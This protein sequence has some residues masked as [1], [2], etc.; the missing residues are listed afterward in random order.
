MPDQELSCPRCKGAM[1]HGFIADSGLQI[2]TWYATVGRGRARAL[3]LF[4]P[5]AEGP[6]RARRANVQVHAMRIPRVV[7]HNGNGVTG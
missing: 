2:R 4:G 1:E 3:V 5:Q 7:R 6:H